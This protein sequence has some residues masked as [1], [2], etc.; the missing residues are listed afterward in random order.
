[1]QTF[2]SL[3]DP[4]TLRRA[5]AAD[6]RITVEYRIIRSDGEVRFIRSIAEGSRT[7]RALLYREY[8]GFF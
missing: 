5:V 4:E 7:S 8:G 3:V 2:L 1:L 6:A